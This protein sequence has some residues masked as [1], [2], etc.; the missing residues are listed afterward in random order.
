MLVVGLFAFGN[1]GGFLLALSM[2]PEFT[3]SSSQ[4]AVPV[5]CLCISVLLGKDRFNTKSVAG[6]GLSALGAILVT[7]A[8]N[9][10]ADMGLGD[11]SNF[12]VGLLCLLVSVCSY[13]C[14][15][16]FLPKL[17]D[18]Y[19]PLTTTAWYYAVCSFFT[20][21]VVMQRLDFSLPSL[22]S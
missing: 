17:S 1:I 10:G 15:Y 5:V 20:F 18:K 4:P 22:M 6:V 9:A 7:T 12:T 2:L 8:S 3:V 16:I 19:P 14:M 13:A 11:S 21:G